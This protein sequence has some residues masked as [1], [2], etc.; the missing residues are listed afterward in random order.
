[1][2]EKEIRIRQAENLKSNGIFPGRY[3]LTITSFDGRTISR[4][5]FDN[6]DTLTKAYQTAKRDYNQYATV[7]KSIEFMID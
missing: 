2:T 1:M 5:Q 6:M 3:Y 4:K 7:K